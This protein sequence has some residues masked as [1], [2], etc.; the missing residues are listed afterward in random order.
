MDLTRPQAPAPYKLMPK[1][2]SFTLTSAD[3]KEGEPMASAQCAEGG[4]TS[5]QLAWEG[6]PQGTESFLVTCFDPDAPTPS[7]FWHWVIT[8]IPAATTELEAGV[9]ASDLHLDGPAMHLRN[10][11]G[12]H[13]YYGPLPPKG[14]GPHRYYF[15]VTALDTPSLELDE[16][17]TPTSA[18]FTANSH[19][20]AR[21]VLMA[22]HET[23]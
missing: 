19:T 3:L 12:E 10:D 16:D 1:A 11:A 17:A 22:T 8:D 4:N 18:V 20:L 7:G 5:P 23:K 15:V 6:F 2:A 14:D 21:A 13:C 9:G